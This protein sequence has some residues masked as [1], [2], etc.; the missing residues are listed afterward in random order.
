M[1]ALPYRKNTVDGLEEDNPVIKDLKAVTTKLKKVQEEEFSKSTMLT[2]LM[3][4]DT[5]SSPMA[6]FTKSAVE[7]TP[8][9]DT[10]PPPAATE[11]SPTL[12]PGGHKPA[13]K[14][15][16]TTFVVFPEQNRK[17]TKNN[18]AAQVQVTY[19]KVGASL[20]DDDDAFTERAF[21]FNPDPIGPTS[22]DTKVPN[23]PETAA[24]AVN[25]PK[26]VE[27]T[28]KL[29]MT[30]TAWDKIHIFASMASNK[31]AETLSKQHR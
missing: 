15:I 18:Q 13:L 9:T 29:P 4:L 27:P 19:S 10:P 3:V 1:D 8:A 5:K 30:A 12:E 25:K 2:R 14:D 22:D 24:G 11:A 6:T 16:V 23:V 28:D 21:T 7:D 20:T 31:M 26:F 17:T